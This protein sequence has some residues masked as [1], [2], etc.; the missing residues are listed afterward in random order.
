MASSIEIIIRSDLG[1]V[2]VS[3]TELGCAND[4]NYLAYELRRLAKAAEKGLKA[5]G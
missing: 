1:D 5:L 3:R 4:S 2:I